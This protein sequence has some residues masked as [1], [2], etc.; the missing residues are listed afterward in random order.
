MFRCP[1]CIAVL[2]EPRAR[3][4]ET[5]GQNLRRRQPLVLGDAAR[6]SSR[7]LPIDRVLA[8]SAARQLAPSWHDPGTSKVAPRVT[9]APVLT[10]MPVPEPVLAPAAVAPAPVVEPEPLIVPLI[11]R[12]HTATSAAPVLDPEPIVE[13]EPVVEPV[14]LHIVEPVVEPEA[15][16]ELDEPEPEPVLDIAP[17]SEPVAPVDV[18]AMDAIEEPAPRVEL[19]DQFAAEL[20][21]LADGVDDEPVVVAQPLP[22]S[23]LEAML[24]PFV[25]APHEVP[26]R[27][28]M[29]PLPTPKPEA[30]ATS[31]PTEPGQILLAVGGEPVRYVDAEME[32]ALDMLARAARE[33]ILA[34]NAP[35]P[36]DSDEPT[37]GVSSEGP[38]LAPIRKAWEPPA[39]EGPEGKRWGFRRK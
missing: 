1:T 18:E 16:L 5:C 8:D 28:H 19:F 30:S 34:A 25:E 31:A 20:A 12:M 37:R 6:V 33:E 32:D 13:A 27:R 2:I 26:M 15:E 14:A 3:R 9:S 10:P 35:E 36:V 4:C 22:L 38:W 29:D 7:H 24:A 39:D 17:I 21:E 11:A 23:P